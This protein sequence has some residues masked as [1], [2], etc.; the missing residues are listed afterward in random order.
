MFIKHLF[1]LLIVVIAISIF[2]NNAAFARGDVLAPADEAQHNELLRDMHKYSFKGYLEPA[3]D[4]HYDEL[5]REIRE[6]RKELA[7]VREFIKLLGFKKPEP[8]ARSTDSA[9]A[10][11][12][13]SGLRNAKASCIMWLADNAEKNNSEKLA[14]WLNLNTD[15]T[16]LKEYL[17]NEKEAEGLLFAVTEDDYLMLGKLEND[18][19]VIE[20]AI[21]M[22]GRA[23][24]DKFGNPLT[25]DSAV[26][27]IYMRVK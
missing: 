22:A 24:F 12:L 20:M 14:S 25:V 17:D 9:K 27:G 7:E 3:D 8:V 23:L 4:M 10:S 6:L 21:G 19:K 13:V 15:K 18:T 11:M 1:K 2:T 26:Y 16:P 5:L